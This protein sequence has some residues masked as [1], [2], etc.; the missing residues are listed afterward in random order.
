MKLYLFTESDHKTALK[1]LRHFMD[2]PSGAGDW[3]VEIGVLAQAIEAYEMKHYPIPTNEVPEQ[4]Y[5]VFDPNTG[6]FVAGPMSCKNWAKIV[7]RDK[8]PTAGA[9]E[10][11]PYV[12]VELLKDDIM[13]HKVDYRRK[14]K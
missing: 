9:P 14:T 13:L 5:Y 7:C 1:H 11:E 12:V 2:D 8:Q 6:G 3:T 10:R 4:R